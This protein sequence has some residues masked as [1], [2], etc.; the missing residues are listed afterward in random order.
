VDAK[1]PGVAFPTPGPGALAAAVIVN[2][3]NKE[4]GTARD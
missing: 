1:Y 4:V 3:K 2:M